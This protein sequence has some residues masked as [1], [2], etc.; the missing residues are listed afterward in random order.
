M[1]CAGSA[2]DYITSKAVV[3]GGTRGLGLEIARAL[4]DIQ[5]IIVG[6]SEIDPAIKE[7]MPYAEFVRADL[8][9]P[10]VAAEK[11]LKAVSSNP[12]PLS[13]FYWVAGEYHRG[14]FVEEKYEKTASMTATHFLGPL[15]VLKA[16]HGFV[17]N[18]AQK[19]PYKLIV[20]GSVF[21]HKPGKNHATLS[22]LKAA[23][24]NFARVFSYELS[25]D[26]P[27]SMTLLVNPWA[28]QTHFFDGYEMDQKMMDKFMAPHEVAR[29]ILD[30]EA[31]LPKEAKPP[32]VELTLDRGENSSIKQLIGPQ[33][34]KH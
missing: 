19:T 7:S 28:M 18:Q 5:P 8:R 10:E 1:C 14:P 12:L 16:V 24:A 29:I 27:G 3:L 20:I 34:V 32:I 30:Q 6:S 2:E 25:A 26:L 9:N 11:V 31:N 23:K 33:P 17:K 22:A 13:A 21:V 15:S 4:R